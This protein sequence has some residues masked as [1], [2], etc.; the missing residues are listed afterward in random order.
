MIREVLREEWNSA[1]EAPVAEGGR[2]PIGHTQDHSLALL[3]VENKGSLAFILSPI[4]EGADGCESSASNDQ[5]IVLRRGK[6][7]IAEEEFMH[8]IVNHFVNG[9]L[10][11]DI[12]KQ[13]LRD[14]LAWQ[15]H[16]V[17]MRVT[18]KLYAVCNLRERRLGRLIYTHK[19]HPHDIRA[20]KASEDKLQ[21]YREKFL[22]SIDPIDRV[23]YRMGTFFMSPEE[24][25]TCS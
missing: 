23:T 13:Y 4:Q 10:P 18:K 5:E 22:A 1:P 20:R 17:P 2:V 12:G 7:T 8:T 9:I 16:C 14:I 6:W 24:N 15:L 11:K 25:Y 3:M 19:L 21:H